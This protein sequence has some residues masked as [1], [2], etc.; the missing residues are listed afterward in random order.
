MSQKSTGFSI[1]RSTAAAYTVT[2]A[3]GS[4][5]SVKRGYVA[6]A[7]GITTGRD[8]ASGVLNGIDGAGLAAPWNMIAQMWLALFLS[9]RPGKG[10][11]RAM[12]WL[13]FLAAAF[14]AG[15]VS[16]PVSHKL[17]TREL[18][19]PDAMVAVANIVLPFVML[20]GALSD[21]VRRDEP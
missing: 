18:P 3:A 21:L 10:G 4:V 8:V 6:Q 14:A 2:F 9:R 20:A 15:A 13:A 17:V 12:A 16:E 19:P 11:R 7:L 5:I 1:A